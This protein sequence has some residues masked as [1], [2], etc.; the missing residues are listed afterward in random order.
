MT[1]DVVRSLKAKEL[2][3]AVESGA[4]EGSGHPDSSYSEAEASVGPGDGAWGAEVVTK[5][6][7]PTLD[8]IARLRTGQV[9]VG[10]LA[11]LTSGETNRALADAGVTAFAIEAIP[12]ITRAWR[13]ARRAASS[14]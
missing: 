3:V 2:E 10:H 9:L 13:R 11:P 1:P 14:R 5:V 8:E 6:G 4:G 7:V 12:R